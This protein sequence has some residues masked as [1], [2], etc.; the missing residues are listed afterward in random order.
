MST[1]RTYEKIIHLIAIDAG[2]LRTRWKIAHTTTLMGV[3]AEEE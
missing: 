2:T 3:D 1:L